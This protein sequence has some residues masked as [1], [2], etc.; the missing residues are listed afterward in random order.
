[1]DQMGVI[2]EMSME[3]IFKSE[4]SSSRDETKQ[5]EITSAKIVAI[6]AESIMVDVGMK[7]EGTIAKDEFKT[8]YLE[9]LKPGDSIPVFLGTNRSRDG[10]PI[11][12]YRR[13]VEISAWKKI[14]NAFREK[15]PLEGK[16]VAKVKGGFLID[17][18][19]E[20]FIPSSQMDIRPVRHSDE[21]IGKTVQVAVTEVDRRKKNVVV[22][23]RTIEEEHQ[24]IIKNKLLSTL[25]VGDV[26]KGKVTSITKFGVFVD[27]G[28]IEG[29]L[30]IGN[31]SWHRIER[32][33]KIIH[34]DETINVQILSI[35]K[36]GDKIALGKKQIE[37]HPWDGIEERY[38]AGSIVEGKVTSLTNFGAFVELENGVEGLLHTTEISW[39]DKNIAPK[40]VFHIGQV[41]RLHVLSVDRQSEKISLSLKRTEEN[42]WEKAKKLYPSGS[43]IQGEISHITPFG[44]FVM[45]PLGIEGL[46]HVSDMS[47]IKRIRHPH[48]VVTVGQSVELK[49]LDV[50]P[51]E[52]RIS[53]GLKHLTPDP[54]EKYR[55]GSHVT[56]TVKRLMD[57][58]AL[59]EIEPDIEAF[60][61]I[62]EMVP[63]DGSQNTRG[64]RLNHPSE[65]MRK[66]DTISA[67]VIRVN[68]NERK[69]DLSVK[70]YEKDIEQREMKKYMN[71]DNRLTLGEILNGEEET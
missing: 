35:D 14:T 52:E 46:I 42:P 6:T 61:H 25:K 54:Y 28:G 8:E 50:I 38:H 48:E 1:M 17:V 47:W 2:E 29:L 67:K 56:G 24:R 33:E 68:R 19:I 10:H 36:N 16:I 40:S 5:G 63:R 37:P 30:H 58:G 23:R 21:W 60:I 43:R 13:A 65:A 12:S 4:E 15:I 39:K 20:A 64:R 49:V 9:Q 41:L 53:L 44:A 27:I 57:F 26:V 55:A 22:S 32:I 11:V 62:S 69:I 59:V 34:I 45:L 71:A 51:E 3:D 66:G 70:K 18:G 31:I 7:A